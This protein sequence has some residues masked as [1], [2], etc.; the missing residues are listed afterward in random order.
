MKKI[1]TILAA[2]ATLLI[3]LLIPATTFAASNSLGVNPRRDY[4]IKSGE[5]INDTIFV[6]NLSATDDLTIDINLVDFQA[7]GQSG[8][9][10]LLL[11]QTQPT[12]WSLK[13][14]MTIQKSATIGAGKSADIP[15]SVIIPKNVGAGSYYS[16][17]RFSAQSANGQSNLNLSG[18][19]ISL[20]FVRVP[21][22]ANDSLQMTKFGAFTPNSDASSGT[23]ASFYGAT[24]PKYISYEL[25][26]AG[27]VA[28]QP[29]GSM[30][31]KNI[32]GKQVKLY[33][34]INP[35]KNLVL[36]DQTRRIDLCLN[37]QQVTKTVN[38]VKTQVEQCNNYSFKPGRYT[39]VMDLF[40]GTNGSSSREIKATASFWYLPPW[41]ITVVVVVLLV[42]AGVV[43]L[44]VNA[45]RNARGQKYRRR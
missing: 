12:R 3:S 39:A 6:R 41:F 10:A 7:Q 18:S 34:N 9:P 42:L 2:F 26:N 33:Q 5:K 14:Y 30:L 21:G 20:I 16:A 29:T 40:Y 35:N 17:V 44:V 11:K 24:A 32:F 45:V 28:E 27:N 38:G 37:P 4:T 36:I 25:K 31:I 43:W 8:A 1:G 15:F 23:Y 19:S 13:P 22:Q